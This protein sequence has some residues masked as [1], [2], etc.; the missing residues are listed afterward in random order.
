M[1]RYAAKFLEIV[2]SEN[3]RQMG[4]PY[5]PAMRG[6][7]VYTLGNKNEIPWSQYFSLKEFFNMSTW[8][9]D[10][11]FPSTEHYFRK[12]RGYE[13]NPPH[14]KSLLHKLQ[15]HTNVRA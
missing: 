10:K 14:S 1:A 12:N 15:A 13:C 2:R 3:R 6:G 4:R 7:E 5:P 9:Q 11:I 8:C